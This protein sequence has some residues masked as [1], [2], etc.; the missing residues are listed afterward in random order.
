MTYLL[1][2]KMAGFGFTQHLLGMFANYMTDRQQ[3]VEYEGK[4]ST[5]FTWS[6]VSQGSNLGPLEFL[7]MINDLPNVVKNSNCLLFA[8]DLKLSL[9]VGDVGD[10]GKLQDDIDRVVKWSQDNVLQFNTSK[11]TVV[12]FTRKHA[13]IEYSYTIEGAPLCRLK[14]IKDLGLKFTTD[15][16]FRD[17]IQDICKK[18]Y[19]TLGFT[20]RTISNFTN[21]QAIMALYNA[22]VRSH[23]ENNA[24]IWA[25]HEKKYDL[26]LEKV[27]NKFTR[28]L[29]YKLYKVYPFYPLQYP[30][31]FVLGMVGYN[32][33]RV[34]RELSLVSYVFKLI[35]G[36]IFNPDILGLLYLEVPDKYVWR[37]RQPNLLAVPKSRTNILQ[38]APL[39]RAFRTLNLM[40]KE[41]DL[42]ICSLSEFTKLAERIISYKSI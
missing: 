12:T 32:K 5:Y 34:R 8:D 14:Q 42:F 37:R 41:T 15:L 10:C 26:M 27:Q 6:G 18:A 28:Y 3:Y 11:C 4:K 21:I 25:P 29:Y 16:T 35:R 23:L 38:E 36:K 30:T 24:M 31:L 9:S 7:I 13:P 39:T 1:L 2:K 22:L 17:H 33:L 40:H 19:R 20:L